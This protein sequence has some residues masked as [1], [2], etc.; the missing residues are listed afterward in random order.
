MIHYLYS[1]HL[2]KKRDKRRTKFGRWINWQLYK[3]LKISLVKYYKNLPLKSLKI[4]T[5]STVIV[6]LTTIPNRIEYV[7][8]PIKSLLN[9]TVPPKKI[10]LWLGEE[11]FT[12]KIEDLPKNL[13]ELIPFGLEIEFCKDL[14]AHTKYYY[15]FQNY[16]ENLVLTIDDDILY[17][18]N[19]I[20]VLLNKY[21]EFPKS[22]VANRVRKIV[23]DENGV[24]PYRDWKI[25]VPKSSREPSHLLLATGV[26]GVLYKPSL[27]SESTYDTEGM[28]KT[29]C[30]G[31]DIWLKAAQIDS[32]LKV[33]KT[34]QFARA[35]IEIEEAQ[36]Q[37]LYKA[38]VFENE[39]DRQ[40]K[41]VFKYF[42][43]DEEIFRN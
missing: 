36:E 38:N 22:V 32:D 4:D 6:S 34:D 7:Y 42:N 20:E 33:V 29:N 24:K 37:S 40:V 28:E 15:T 12:S 26:S 18:K 3:Y 9:Q 5:E 10:V 35:F 14:K 1:Y 27:F 41:E 13:R 30:I 19:L 23:V 8:L 39:N 11:F 31:D 43:I 21:N 2:N 17:P 16:K 25:N